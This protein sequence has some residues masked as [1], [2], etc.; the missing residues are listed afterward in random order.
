MTIPSALTSSHGDVLSGTHAWSP[1]PPSTSAARN[2]LSQPFK[3]ELTLQSGT[4]HMTLHSEPAWLYS[5]FAQIQRLAGLRADWDSYG[6]MPPSDYV[7][8]DALKVVLYT[9][10]TESVAPVIVPTSDGGVQLEWQSANH[11]LEIRVMPGGEVSGIRE[12]MASG[13]VVDLARVSV[14]DMASIVAFAGGGR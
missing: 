14:E 7:L 12:D 1:Q 10:T 11:D 5:T 13:V 3:V 6:G 2:L 9:S 4:I 8:V